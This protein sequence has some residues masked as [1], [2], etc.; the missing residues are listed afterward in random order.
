M[1]DIMI[2]DIWY[3][4]VSKESL[5]FKQSSSFW[6][7][8]QNFLLW[9]D[10]MSSPLGSA[11]QSPSTAKEVHS[12]PTDKMF[13]VISYKS[14]GTA[15]LL[16]DHFMLS[17][18]QTSWHQFQFPWTVRAFSLLLSHQPCRTPNHSATWEQHHSLKTFTVHK[19]YCIS[20]F[21]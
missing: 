15:V 2:Y 21:Q 12:L 5:T 8:E 3:L 10:L 7:Q 11:E 13:S 6:G 18:L 9:L 4:S 16:F 19:L 1:I 20:T 14:M 17:Q